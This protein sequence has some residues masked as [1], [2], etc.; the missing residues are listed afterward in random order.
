MNTTMFRL[1]L[2]RIPYF[3]LPDGY[4]MR[5]YQSGDIQY[6][7]DFHIPLFDEGDIT[8]DLFWREYGYDEA[9]LAQRQFYMTHSETV[10]GSISA[11]FGDDERGQD[12]GRIHW[13]VLREDYQGRGL[14]KPLLSYALNK[15]KELGHTQAYLTTGTD[16]IPALSLYLKFGFEP[17]IRTE[18]EQQAWD[19]VYKTLGLI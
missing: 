13:V 18:Q 2:E 3:E 8:E 5:P 19:I 9:V 6:W 17:E 4:G 1:D 15:L 11:W 12:L 10:I 7:L 16:L 14:A